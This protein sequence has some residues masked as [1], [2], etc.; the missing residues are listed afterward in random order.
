[1]EE[2]TKRNYYK[3]WLQSERVTIIKGFFLEDVNSVQLS[4]WPRMEGFGAYVDFDA[5]F[6][7]VNSYVCEIPRG[8]KLAPEKHLFEEVIYVLEGHGH[9]T[10]WD[11]DIRQSFEWGKDSLFTIPLNVSHQH[12][13]DNE[14]APA[15][16][17]AVTT[18][19]FMINLFRDLDFIFDNP[20]AFKNRYSGQADYWTIDAKLLGHLRTHK[21]LGINLVKNLRQTAIQDRTGSKTVSYLDFAMADSSLAAYVA[22]TPTG[23]YST[24]HRHGPSAHILF[25][26]GKG[27]TLFW[28]EGKDK[29]RVDWG[30]GSMVVPPNQIFH[31]HFNTGNI[32]TLS[33]RVTLAP[34]VSPF[35]SFGDLVWPTGEV[36]QIEHK[37]EDPEI[38]RTFEEELARSG[39]GTKR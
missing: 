14:S 15:R 29:T 13:N 25:L 34:S 8:T 1:M 20:F 36:D 39:V 5:S 4:Q 30:P 10:V 38:R 18:A 31:Q 26:E 35:V 11:A 23:A 24:A 12:F 6:G 17:L 3:E 22:Q 28:K 16:Y 9:T 33:L 37:D 32:P 21:L 27:Y 2:L 7:I 19:P